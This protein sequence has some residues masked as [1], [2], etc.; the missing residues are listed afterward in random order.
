LQEFYI[1]KSEIEQ[2]QQESALGEVHNFQTPDFRFGPQNFDN[3]STTVTK[4][5]P[6]SNRT[7]DSRKTAV[8][9]TLARERDR[10]ADR[11]ISLAELTQLKRLSRS[12]HSPFHDVNGDAV[13]C[14]MLPPNFRIIVLR[15]VFRYTCC[16]SKSPQKPPTSVRPRLRVL[17]GDDI[18][19]GPGKAE[20]L[21]AI[22]QTGS[23]AAAAKRLGMSYMRAW[24]LLQTMNHCFKSPVVKAAR[25]F[26]PRGTE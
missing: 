6:V 8:R 7:T 11:M 4:R 5:T 20:L 12:N 10:R 26:E 15:L 21:E 22:D 18:A 23:L 3:A 14:E 13:R 9:Q 2:G 19:L 17:C 16:M 1:S 24:S 25:R